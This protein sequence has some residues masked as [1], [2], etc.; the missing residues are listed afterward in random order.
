MGKAGLVLAA[1]QVESFCEEHG[2]CVPELCGKALWSA[3]A[4]DPGVS[5]AEGCATDNMRGASID[6]WHRPHLS[7]QVSAFFR[8]SSVAFC[9]ELL[10][11]REVL[12][13]QVGTLL[14]ACGQP[15]SYLLDLFIQ[16][17]AVDIGE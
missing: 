6:G 8:V 9:E 3:Q 14:L 15:R 10:W 7:D 2:Y 12:M 16:L 11:G 4:N 5:L 13:A 17:V 1:C